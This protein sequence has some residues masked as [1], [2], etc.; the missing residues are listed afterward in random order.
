MQYW[1]TG[2]LAT[3]RPHQSIL[4]NYF[5]RSKAE[6]QA[7]IEQRD[8][9]PDY[10]WTTWQKRDWSAHRQRRFD[11]FTNQGATLQADLKEL[12]TKG[13]TDPEA[14][15]TLH[16]RFAS[17][18]P[19]QPLRHALTLHRLRSFYPEYER[20]KTG[21]VQWELARVL[22]HDLRPLGLSREALEEYETMLSKY[23][24]HR[25]VK[26]GSALYDKAD[27]R[28]RIALDLAPSRKAEAIA[29]LR[30]ALELFM[31]FQRDF[32]EHYGN[33]VPAGGSSAAQRRIAD[34][35]ADLTRLTGR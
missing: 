17:N 11:Y 35:R 30:K 34:T 10:Q 26:E 24:E 18:T 3:P 12:E 32:P 16:R 1:E 33:R 8:K 7:Y 6:W 20:V 5:Q 2:L 27:A 31:K 23:P 15:W 4:D 21:D 28:R 19:E 22:H 13:A 29:G 14:F 9:N 25:M